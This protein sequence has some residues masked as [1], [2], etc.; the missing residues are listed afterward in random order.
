MAYSRC[1]RTKALYKGTQISF[2]KH[3]NDLFMKYNIPLALLAAVRTLA[4]GVN[5]EFIVMPRKLICSHFCNDLPS[6]FSGRAMSRSEE[7]PFD[8]LHLTED[9]IYEIR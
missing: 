3:V 2:V 9:L 4:E 7:P 1:G 8:K 6:A 5:A